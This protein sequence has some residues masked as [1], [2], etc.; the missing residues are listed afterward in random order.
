MF[1]QNTV[2][3]KLNLCASIWLALMNTMAECI[4]MY[5]VLV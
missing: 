1:A 5:V 2:D 3:V 4:Q